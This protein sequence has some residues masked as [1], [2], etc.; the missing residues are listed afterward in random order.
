MRTKFRGIAMAGVGLVVLV[1]A[2]KKT[3]ETPG[4][5]ASAA[6]PVTGALGTATITGDVKFVGKAPENPVIDMSDEPKCRADYPAAYPVSRAMSR[7]GPKKFRAK[8]L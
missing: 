8:N 4:Q 3:E 7:T 2:C 1:G 5:G 6:A